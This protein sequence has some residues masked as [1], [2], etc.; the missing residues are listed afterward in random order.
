MR[1]IITDHI[2]QQAPLLG[3]ARKLLL[4]A[5]RSLFRALKREKLIFRE[6]SWGVG[7]STRSSCKRFSGTGNK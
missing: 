3:E 4:G 2:Q 7:D 6:G 5:L 1:A